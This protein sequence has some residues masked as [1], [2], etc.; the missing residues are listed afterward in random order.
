MGDQVTSYT[1][2]PEPLTTGSRKIDRFAAP[3]GKLP[4]YIIE[5][6]VGAEGIYI[7]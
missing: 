4:G 2:E 6:M 1:E 3:S 5:T 7:Y